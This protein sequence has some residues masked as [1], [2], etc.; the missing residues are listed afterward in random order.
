MAVWNG[1]R[2]DFKKCLTIK[3]Q[4]FYFFFNDF[5]C[6]RKKF[7][8]PVHTPSLNCFPIG[9]PRQIP[10]LFFPGVKNFT[11][12]KKEW[13]RKWTMENKA[14]N[15]VIIFRN[16]EKKRESMDSVTGRNTHVLVN[17]IQWLSLWVFKEFQTAPPDTL[18]PPLWL[19]APHDSAERSICA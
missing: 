17:Q 4:I 18:R 19:Q 10:W 12:K 14:K 7:I 1:C 8:L 11:G 3:H 2:K 6:L 5:V 15:D 13:N 16:C 9:Q